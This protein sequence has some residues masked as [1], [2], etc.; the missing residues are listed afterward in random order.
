MTV[1]HLT[2]VVYEVRDTDGTLLAAVNG[3]ERAQ[4]VAH[5]LAEPAHLRELLEAADQACSVL[6]SS[7]TEGGLLSA[8]MRHYADESAIRLGR[9][10][11]PFEE[12]KRQEVEGGNHG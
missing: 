2:G 12:P 5:A 4:L 11:L 10:L 9:A 1:Q 3:E 8:A 7:W 6:G